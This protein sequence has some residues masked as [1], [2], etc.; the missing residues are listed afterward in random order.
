V[1]DEFA[2]SG[3]A[4]FS[5]RVFDFRTAKGYKC[6]CHGKEFHGVTAAQS[7]CRVVPHSNRQDAR[8]G[9]ETPPLPRNCERPCFGAR[10]IEVTEAEFQPELFRPVRE[11]QTTEGDA[12]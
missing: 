12:R 10:L 4:N 7:L 6:W 1:R 9:G 3:I 11:A 5:L 8:E 2:S